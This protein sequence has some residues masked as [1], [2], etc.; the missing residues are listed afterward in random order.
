VALPLRTETW[1]IWVCRIDCGLEERMNTCA[2][3]ATVPSMRTLRVRFM[4][5]ALHWPFTWGWARLVGVASRTEP[6]EAPATALSS[7]PS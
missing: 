7:K 1:R 5:S 4:T 6:L 3:P 2:G